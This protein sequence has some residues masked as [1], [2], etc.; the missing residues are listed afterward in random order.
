MNELEKPI[1]NL[2]APKWQA[3]P[4][5][6]WLFWTNGFK[7]TNSGN[8]ICI[9]NLIRNAKKSGFQVREVNNSNIE[10]YIGK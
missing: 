8:K 4:K 1:T 6:I 10:Y 7:K 5:I 2:T 9:E 3:L